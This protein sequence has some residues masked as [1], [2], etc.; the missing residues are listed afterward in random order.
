MGDFG[1]KYVKIRPIKDRR[2][3]TT[4]INKFNRQKD[5]NAIVNHAV[6]E[7]LLWENNKVGTET[8]AHEYIESEFNDNDIHHIYNTSLNHKKENIE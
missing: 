7:I 8:E 6:D 1:S 3:D 4:N 2:H 5:K